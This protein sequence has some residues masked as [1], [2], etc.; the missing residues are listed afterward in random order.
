[1]S[2]ACADSFPNGLP[3]ALDITS[4]DDYYLTVDEHREW[5]TS[6]LYPLLAPHQK[7]FL[8]PGSYGTRNDIPKVRSLVNIPRGG[9]AMNAVVAVQSLKSTLRNF[10]F[11]SGLPQPAL[12]IGAYFFVQL[13][14]S[15]NLRT[16]CSLGG[17]SNRTARQVKPLT[18][19]TTSW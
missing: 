18:I 13:I 2:T 1:M 9:V 10:H 19:A 14:R 15:F 17:A 4:I 5:Y 12:C 3:A 8:V 6:K 11:V 16:R 7:V